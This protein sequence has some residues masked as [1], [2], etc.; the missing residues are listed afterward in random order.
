MSYIVSARKYRPQQFDEV[1]GQ[2]HV[3]ST[4]QKA[5]DSDKIAHA[6]LFCGPRGVGKTSCARIMAK[7]L[8]C[9]NKPNAHTACNECSS[10]KAFNDNASF[11][12]IELDA[13]S[14]NSVENIRTLIEQ[15]RF[16]PQQGQYKIFIIDEVHM[17]ST[18]AFNAF[19]K[20]LEEPP[21]Y[22]IFILATTEKHK[23]IPTILSRC[24]VFD[25]KRIQTSDMVAQLKII[26]EAE[27]R[28]YEV[29]GL[30]II[31]QKADGAMRDALSIFDRIASTGDT[32]SYKQ[33]VESLNILDYDVFFN[34]VDALMTEDIGSIL[35]QFSD[36][37]RRGFDPDHFINGLAGHFRNLLVAKEE[38]TMSLL[39]LSDQLKTKYITQAKLLSADFLLTAMNI[40]NQCDINF[41]KAKNKNLHT[42]IA[43][44]KMAK[45]NRAIDLSKLA[46]EQPKLELRTANKTA[47]PQS[48]TQKIP[49]EKEVQKTVSVPAK[50]A[51]PLKKLPRINSL[52]EL[53]KQVA[54]EEA[55]NADAGEEMTDENLTALW[56]DYIDNVESQATA[57]SLKNSI[58]SFK[59]HS[60]YAVVPSQIARETV[61]QEVALIERIRVNFNVNDL[62]INVVVDIDQFPDFNRIEKPKILGAHDKFEKLVQI[63]PLVADLVK[64]FDLK[65][66]SE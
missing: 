34:V 22:A 33:V 39:D 7:V 52:E 66:D 17:L 32:I 5:L 64:K 45:I 23:I 3:S 43:L 11:N 20:T 6:F 56:K 40:A 55:R 14:N 65:P 50:K 8:N 42:E 37:I 29:E 60:V 63:N 12:I 21:P 53:V 25:F 44:C 19:L 24:Q 47:A 1:L 62:A 16:Q 49:T 10:C 9:E 59:D 26:A 28:E 58:V 36:I 31:A 35:L 15:V 61:L 27:G 13:A 38:S 2:S 54:E 41:P 57:S 51:T 18:S 4:L 48:Y 46:A 30:H